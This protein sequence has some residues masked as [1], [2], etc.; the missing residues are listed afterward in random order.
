MLCNTNQPNI[1]GDKTY[2]L[3]QNR[4][5]YYIKNME[6]ITLLHKNM[7]YT[8]LLYKTW[9]MQHYYINTWNRQHYY[10]KHG[11]DNIIT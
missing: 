8:T 6:Q 4:Q 5:H 9:N 1:T 3:K 2:I 7:E 10:I 11:I